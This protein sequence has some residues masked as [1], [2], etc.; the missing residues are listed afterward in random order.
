[1]D[2]LAELFA[3]TSADELDAVVHVG[4]CNPELLASYRARRPRRLVVVDG[5]PGRQAGRQ[6][7]KPGGGQVE[8]VVTP[9]SAQG[10]P[11]H[12]HRSN[13]RRVD[14]VLRP[15]A[16]HP[17]YPGLRLLDAVPVTTSALTPLLDGL[18]I[19]DG[20][21]RNNLL[22]LDLPGLAAE[23]LDSLGGDGPRIFCWL[24]LRTA[25]RAL[26]DG[27]LAFPAALDRLERDGYQILRVDDATEPAWPAALLRFDPVRHALMRARSELEQARASL[28]K[29]DAAVVSAERTNA[30]LQGR[31]EEKARE[32]QEQRD[33]VTSVAAERETL[34][35]RQAEQA[36]R[37]EQELAEIGQTLARTVRLLQLRDADLRDLQER[38]RENLAKQQTQHQLLLDVARHLRTAVRQFKDP[39]D[40]SD[41][42][43]D[44]PS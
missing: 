30:V 14:G 42:G 23:L 1:M 4:T 13:L 17:M 36:R 38:Y 20:E 28:A 5:T 9:V 25:A 11:G 6:G 44:G 7:K 34:D 3:G 15:V 27:A 43:P 18:R 21:R 39:A 31:L 12:W 16:A 26:H 40:G 22:V 35:A 24:L 19:A 2:P 41:A 8:F 37:L 29:R 33:R 10:G 32:L